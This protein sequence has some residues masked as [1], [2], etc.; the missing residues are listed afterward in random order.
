MSS[1]ERTSFGS[2]IRVGLDGAYGADWVELRE[3]QCIVFEIE[4]RR[5]RC[6]AVGGDEGEVIVVWEEGRGAGMGYD[7]GGGLGVR[8]ARGGDERGFVEVS[9]VASVL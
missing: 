8:V 2:D 5:P 4:G 9:M 6:W 1:I 7:I 3:S